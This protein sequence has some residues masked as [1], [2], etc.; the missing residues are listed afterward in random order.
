MMRAGTG[1]AGA[2]PAQGTSVFR[3]GSPWSH[4]VIV[5]LICAGLVNAASMGAALFTI[6]AWYHIYFDRQNLPDLVPFIRFEFPTI[7]GVYDTNGQPLIELAREYRH[8][9]PYADI[10]PIVSEAILAAEDRHFFSHNGVDY[11]SL[12]R[13]IGKVRMSAW[14]TRLATGGRWDTLPG[15]TIFPQGGSTITQQLVRGVFLQR[16]TSQENS[17][18][19]RNPRSFRT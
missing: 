2:A 18:E 8:I 1:A 17:A 12:P 9:T 14:R 15:S 11:L 10:P 13:V 7:G 5:L 6:S 16:L 4:G 19:L 3:S